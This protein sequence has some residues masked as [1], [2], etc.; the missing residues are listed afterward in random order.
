LISPTL[1]PAICPLAPLRIVARIFFIICTATPTS[2]P[3]NSRIHATHLQIVA[4]ISGSQY[5]PVRGTTALQGFVRCQDAGASRALLVDQIKN[6]ANDGIIEP[7]SAVAR[8]ASGERVPAGAARTLAGGLDAMA[9]T[10]LPRGACR[11]KT[12]P[13]D[14]KRPIFTSCLQSVQAI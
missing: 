10:I 14:A 2:G 8:S 7:V 12:A 1:A 5:G 9:I 11:L 6:P 13:R 3:T 4:S